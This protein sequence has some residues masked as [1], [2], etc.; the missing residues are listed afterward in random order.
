MFGSFN[1]GIQYEY[2]KY[3]YTYS[4]VNY[5]V[6]I[7]KTNPGTMGIAGAVSQSR[8]NLSTMNPDSSICSPNKVIAK[9][10]GNYLDTSSG[11]HSLNDD[12]SPR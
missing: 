6:H 8:V 5:S 10:N 1:T 4:A 12:R 11:G 2:G 7:F 3:T 9:I